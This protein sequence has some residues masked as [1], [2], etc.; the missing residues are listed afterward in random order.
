MN[1]PV[2]PDQGGTA[3]RDF[4][5]IVVG[6]G[7]GGI[8][9]V[10]KFTEMGMSVLGIEGGGD[11]GGVWYHNR[12]PGAR[13]DLESLD[14]C[15]HFDDKLFREWKWKERYATQPEILAYLNHVA[16]RYD[17]KRHFLFNTRMTAGQWQPDQRRYHVKTDTG[18]EVT[19]RFLI[20]ATGNLSVPRKLDFP[21]LDEFKGETV[22]T[23]NWPQREV[24]FKD[25]RIG[26]IG[27]GA[28]GVQA[29]PLMAK[30]A[31]HLYV[32][33]RTANYSV[34]AQNG[35]LDQGK[36][37]RC[38][39]DLKAL[40]DGFMKHP[41]GSTLHVNLH[42]ASDYT[43]AEQQALL[44]QAW[45]RGGHYMQTVFGDQGRSQATNDM[46]SE[47]VRNKIR[48]IVKDPAVAQKLLPYA[49]PIGTRRLCV[50]TGY[51]D[52]Y[53]RDNVTLV[54]IK[55]DPID[56]LN[57]TGLR[58]QGG[59]QVD[60]DLLVF[61]TGFNAFTGTLDPA[62]IRNAEGKMPSDYW[63]RGPRTF[64]GLM[65]AGF[66]NLFIVT[67]PGSPSVLA[68]MIVGNVQHMDLIAEFFAHM[69]R[70]GLTLIEPTEEGQDAWTREVAEAASQVLRLKVEN[71]MV[72]VSADPDQKR[73]FVPFIGG[74]NRYVTKCREVV[75]RGFE[76]LRFA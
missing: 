49:Y 12:Y 55:E 69:K 76:G 8:Y 18:R 13:V 43:P 1:T 2:Q 36:F 9:G 37:E 65:S 23:A 19:G 44:E 48:S 50:D 30:E 15:F 27:T 25:R 51:Y 52:T 31:K 56:R 28:S 38:A 71:Y 64:L 35:P 16:E 74:F 10:H 41:G 6:G 57:A 70:Q 5:V 61:A 62:N 45:Q 7:M 11:V 24:T 59:K 17:I 21:G 46:V 58:T 14:Y 29:I 34:P 26:I 4:D 22:Q 20:M 66:P 47:F 53:N 73:T 67:G 75:D 63:K 60:L 72:H 54:D 3:V 68:N 32:F 40:W 39:A 42:P 33:Q